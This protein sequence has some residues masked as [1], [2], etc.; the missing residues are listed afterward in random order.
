M[1]TEIPLYS[2]YGESLLSAEPG[3]VHIE[4]ISDRSRDL[5]WVIKAHR[6]SQLFQILCILEG[7]A[8]VRLNQQVS[9]LSKN[10]VVA[11]P[12]GVVHG[13]RFEPQIQGFVLSLDNAIIDPDRSHAFKQIASQQQAQIIELVES[14][15]DCRR[16]LSYAELIKVESNKPAIDQ[17]DAMAALAQL[18]IISLHR[19]LKAQRISVLQGEEESHILARFMQLLDQ[20]YQ[21]HWA[22]SRYAS[23]LHVSTSTL[24]RLCHRFAGESPKTV[25]QARVIAD[26]R[27]R[28]M[29]TR[30]SIEYIAHDLGFKDQAYFSRFFKK[31][32]GQTPAA[33]RK[34]VYR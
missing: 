20:H 28:L 27:R 13:F 34:Q 14:S 32:Q 6:H 21:E 29:Y 33:Y 24:S 17:N 26:A 10:S 7:Q 12:S 19:L 31:I 11:I 9:T 5:G 30:Q 16:F 3:L 1:K 22:V 25:I 8:E 2:L 18:A 15:E 23:E 4:N